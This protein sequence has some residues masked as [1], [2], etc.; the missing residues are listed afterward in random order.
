MG[1]AY[2]FGTPSRLEMLEKIWDFLIGKL[3]IQPQKLWATYFSGDELNGLQIPSDSETIEALQQIGVSPFQMVGLGAE[4]NLLKEG[5]GDSPEKRWRKLGPM[6]EFFFDR[7]EQWRCGAECRAGCQ[8]GRFIEVSNTLFIYS[9]FDE[10][11]KT[12]TEFQTPFAETVIGIERLATA[13]LGGESLFDIRSTALL[14]RLISSYK[15]KKSSFEF[16]QKLNSERVIAD[17]I[18]ALV[19]LVADGAPPSGQGGRQWIIKKLIRGVLTHQK[20][21]EIAQTNFVQKIIE[22]IICD[23]DYYPHL[24]KANLFLEDYIDEE[25]TRFEKTLANGNSRLDKI[26]KR[27]NTQC[28]DEQHLIDLVKHYG[29]PLPLLKISLIRM[30][31][32]LN[33]DTL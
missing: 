2:C 16:V 9:L 3:G 20:L 11:T 21:L 30:E 28:I 29:F 24:K 14:I 17:H 1:G 33:M 13:L 22:T 31:I 32:D 15:P 5:L 27:G 7:G 18:R 6:V 19:F 4:A 26:I 8:C 12:I 10:T 23:Y 25:S